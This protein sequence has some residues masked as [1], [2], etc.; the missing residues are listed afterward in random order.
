MFW[1]SCNFAWRKTK[2]NPESGIY[3]NIGVSE[4]RIDTVFV[5]R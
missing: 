5:L 2:Q 3:E 1:P 4:I